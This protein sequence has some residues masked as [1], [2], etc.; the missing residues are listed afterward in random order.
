MRSRLSNTCKNV[1]KYQVI[2]GREGLSETFEKEHSIGIRVSV[3]QGDHVLHA[4]DKYSKNWYVDMACIQ[5]ATPAAKFQWRYVPIQAQLT[6]KA[7]QN[8]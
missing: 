3:R 8:W 5:A 4:E 7:P 1:S 6:Q 2:V